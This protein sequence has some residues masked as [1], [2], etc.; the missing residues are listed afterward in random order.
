MKETHE[1][2]YKALSKELFVGQVYLRV[3]NDQPDF[4]ISEPELFCVALV[5]FIASLVHTESGEDSDVLS[6]AESGGPS[7]ETSDLQVDSTDEQIDGDIYSESLAVSDK[8]VGDREELHLVKN[9]RFGLT[10]LKV[11]HICV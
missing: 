7:S 2:A 8:P 9:L 10:S 1:F 6:K 11:S 5:E 4:E 3:Y